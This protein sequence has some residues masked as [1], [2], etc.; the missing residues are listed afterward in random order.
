MEF[1][2]GYVSDVVISNVTIQ[3][4]RHDWFWWGDGDPFH[5]RVIQRSEIHPDADW[6]EEPPAGSISNV[7][8]ENV[9]ARGCS[10]SVCSGHADSWLEGITMRD[11]R[12]I[13]TVD[14]EAPY[15]TP[16]PALIFRHVRD[17]R[18]QNI[19]V[20][21]EGPP[22]D[23]WCGALDIE[24]V[25]ELTLQGIH[26][27][28]PPGNRSA[29]VIELKQVRHGTISA[30]KAGPDTDTF[31]RVSGAHTEDIQIETN[32]LGR[33]KTACL[34]EDDVGGR[35]VEGVDDAS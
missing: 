22:S 16:G 10:P 4:R 23:Q 27:A 26:A 28:S 25:Q 30:C 18:L 8:I 19:D 13:L 35:H 24:E 11:V 6:P 7:L 2:G 29:P 1:D 32:D 17:L 12:L 20:V 14:P 9:V 3:C 31:L 21:W 34:W 15:V 33:A 5:F